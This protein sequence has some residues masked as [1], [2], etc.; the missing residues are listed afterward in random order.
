MER[1]PN[2]P[3][4]GHQSVWTTLP[5]LL[6]AIAAIVTAVAGLSAVLL[7]NDD[8]AADRSETG[9]A[10]QV[11]GATATSQSA[12]P[13]PSRTPTATPTAA[14]QRTR[15]AAS[16]PGDWPSSRSAYTVVLASTQ[17]R[18]EAEAVA[19]QA[20]GALPK[21]GV[22]RSG[23][24]SSLRSGYWVAF[25][26]VFGGKTTATRNATD[27]RAAG[28]SRAYVRWVQDE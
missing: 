1:S 19:D 24:Y 14:A 5:A 16:P 26:G 9:G 17:A 13:V 11:L 22:L 20:R 25:S 10:G 8:S 3:H 21:V 27:A 4:K 28:F 23:D 18:A 2:P 12:T 7:R 6:T 15:P